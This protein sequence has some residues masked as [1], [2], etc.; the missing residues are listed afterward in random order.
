MGG[1]GDQNFKPLTSTAWLLVLLMLLTVSLVVASFVIPLYKEDLAASVIVY[2]QATLWFI[3]FICERCWCRERYISRTNGYLEFYRLTQLLH[4]LPLLVVSACSV[5]M[6]LTKALLEE[7]FPRESPCM[8]PKKVTYQQIIVSIQLLPLALILVRY[9]VH[10]CRFNRQRAL[11]DVC[12]EEY[13]DNLIEPQP[14]VGQRSESCLEE[15]LDKQ[16][17][18][19][20]YLKQHNVNLGHQLIQLRQNHHI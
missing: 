4:R 13:I 7:F 20:R 1:S 18:M 6:L 10:T 3:C 19:I 16:A 11:P 5:V 9:L 15:I 17:D 14:Y 12:T 8:H 2:C